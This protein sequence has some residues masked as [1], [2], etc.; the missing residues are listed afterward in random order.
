MGGGG[1]GGGGGKHL[2]NCMYGGGETY[3][4]KLVTL[5]GCPDF[6]FGNEKNPHTVGTLRQGFLTFQGA[7]SSG[8]LT[9]RGVLAVLRNHTVGSVY[10]RGLYLEDQ[11]QLITIEEEAN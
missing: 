7:T 9:L 4:E 3:I 1:G 10:I 8:C 2:P 6:D 11:P 5:N